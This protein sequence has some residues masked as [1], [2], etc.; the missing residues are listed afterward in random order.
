MTF[1]F[2]EARKADVSV[3]R[4]CRI[5]GVSQSGYYAWKTRPA[6]VGNGKTW[7]FLL[8]FGMRFPFRTAPK[9]APDLIRGQPTDDV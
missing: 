1:K 2:I 3:S 6:S 4:A 9:P 7:S 8:M 5:F